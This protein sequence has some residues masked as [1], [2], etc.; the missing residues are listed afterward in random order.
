M[1]D[2]A[3]SHLPAISVFNLQDIIYGPLEVVP[4]RA[5]KFNVTAYEN[6]VKHFNH[7]NKLD[8]KSFMLD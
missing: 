1:L 7:V 6:I 4:M 3:P 5:G 8:R 2:D